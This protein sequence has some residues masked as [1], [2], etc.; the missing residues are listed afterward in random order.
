M[1]RFLWKAGGLEAWSLQRNSGAFFFLNS[2]HLSDR[3]LTKSLFQNIGSLAGYPFA[4]YLADGVG[5]RGS[6]F[7]GALVMC[8]AVAI[9]TA[10]Q[11][12]G[13]FIGARLVQCFARSSR[14]SLI[15]PP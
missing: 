15:N 1:E 4:P 5:R 8:V 7:F 14:S 10:A 11:S 3:I 9:Q 6:V 13:M 12:I 2:L